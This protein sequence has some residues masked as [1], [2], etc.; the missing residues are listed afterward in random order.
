MIEKIAIIGLLSCPV[1][2]N[3]NA[4]DTDRLDQLEQEIQET[5]RRLSTLESLLSNPSNT[6]KPVAS[7]EG[8]KSVRNWRKLTTGMSTK[9]VQMILGE[10]HRV[11]GGGYTT[12]YYQNGGRVHFIGPFVERW[13]EP[14]Q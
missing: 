14:R 11:D 2:F 9:D 3:A 8:S 4:H 1:A 7:G 5:K 10:P 6:Q 12:W 13:T